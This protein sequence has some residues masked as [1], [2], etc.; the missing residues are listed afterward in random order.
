MRYPAHPVARTAP[1]HGSDW[2]SLNA[3]RFLPLL[4]WLVEA[5]CQSS[6]L[7]IAVESELAQAN[8][9]S[10][11]HQPSDKA[12][13]CADE[14]ICRILGC[15]YGLWSACRTRASTLRASADVQIMDC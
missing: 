11:L 1:G 3:L 5:T 4:A 14:F 10:V 7:A 6:R 15:Q 2:G 9:D 13:M 12:I 8:E